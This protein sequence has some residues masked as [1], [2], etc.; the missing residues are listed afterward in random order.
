M[1]SQVLILPANSVTSFRTSISSLRLHLRSPL[2]YL[3]VTGLSTT[4]KDSL[5]KHAFL[6]QV[7]QFNCLLQLQENF[8]LDEL[9]HKAI[10]S[11]STLKHRAFHLQVISQLLYFT[12]PS[13]FGITSTFYNPF[14]R[15]LLPTCQNIRV[16]F[17]SH[18][19]SLKI[20]SLS[21]IWIHCLNWH[22][23][24]IVLTGTWGFCCNIRIGTSAGS[25]HTPEL[26]VHL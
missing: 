3:Q 6:F 26:W 1:K 14:A 12:T 24:S 20:I 25:F 17:T 2:S 23:L 10:H 21:R 13:S 22:L 8:I 16:T 5:W 7:K 11:F 9:Q 4:P 15:G 19:H 18:T